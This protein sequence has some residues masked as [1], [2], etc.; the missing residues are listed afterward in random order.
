M[1]VLFDNGKTDYGS[2]VGIA[3]C[4]ELDD[5]GVGVRV[6]E[7]QRIFTSP[8]RPDMLWGPPDFLSNGDRWL[9]PRG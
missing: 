1:F 2:V 6:P 7:W 4:Y 5:R 8:C 9:F 3:T